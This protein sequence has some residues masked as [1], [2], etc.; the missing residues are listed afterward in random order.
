M[1]KS[2]VLHID[3]LDVL[4]DL[5]KDQIAD[6]FLAIKDFHNDEGIKLLGV[7]NAVFSPFKNQFT[8]DKKKYENTCKA[9]AEAGSMGGKQKVAN[10][11]KC[12]QKVENLAESVSENDNESDKEKKIQTHTYPPLRIKPEHTGQD[13]RLMKKIQKKAGAGKV[14]LSDYVFLSE[15]QI[16]KLMEDYGE[17]KYRACIEALDNHIPN[18]TTAQKYTDHNRAIRKW[19]GDS[20]DDK[21]NKPK[22]YYEQQQEEE[23]SKQDEHRR[24]DEALMSTFD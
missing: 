7:M 21:E 8:R 9:R 14:Q 18:S 16:E 23:K 12:Q 17:E 22:T 1:K 5:N 10:A 3:S 15:K 19:V 11:S 6:L 2:F 13:L 24:L 20:Y 4:D